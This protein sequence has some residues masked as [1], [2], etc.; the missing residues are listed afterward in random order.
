M[1][2]VIEKVSEFTGINIGDIRSRKRMHA[3]SEARQIFV[4][5]TM[6]VYGNSLSS[7]AEYLDGRTPQGISSQMRTFEQ[8]MKIYKGLNKRVNDI[9][10][11]II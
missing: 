3:I 1:D 8:Q 10:N 9:K 7:I 6:T 2:E 11:A 5:I 4:Y